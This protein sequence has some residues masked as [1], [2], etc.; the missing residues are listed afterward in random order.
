MKQING[1]QFI[2]LFEQFSPKKYALEHD[3]IGLQIGTLNKQMKNVLVT[4]DVTE[5]VVKE[6]IA[7]Q[8]DLII[9]HHP[10]IFRPLKRVTT[11]D[12]SGKITYELDNNKK[13]EI[14]R[15]FKKKNPKIFNENME[16]ISKEFSI[17]KTK[18]NE[19][20]YEQTKVDEDLFL[21]TLSSEIRKPLIDDELQ[22]S[23]PEVGEI[24]YDKIKQERNRELE[25]A[26]LEQERAN[27]ERLRELALADNEDELEIK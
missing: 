24:D 27:Q 8:V 12:F 9:A 18:G 4:L 13:Y 6:A 3:P 15:D 19:F 10:F 1:H 7:K 5:D 17:D 26:R 16:D 25:I 14:F 20:F 23:M 2:Q 21:S 22:I 11:D